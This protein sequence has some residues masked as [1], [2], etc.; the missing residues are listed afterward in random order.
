LM[1]SIER[2]ADA[3][4]D[5]ELSDLGFSRAKQVGILADLIRRFA[6]EA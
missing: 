2:I 5:G 4:A 6:R 3:A 1:F